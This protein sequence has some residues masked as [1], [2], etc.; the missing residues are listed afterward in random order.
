L[1]VEK[2]VKSDKL[3]KKGGAIASEVYRKKVNEQESKLTNSVQRT[4]ESDRVNVGF[5]GRR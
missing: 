1:Q 4:K 2:T 5:G 3:I